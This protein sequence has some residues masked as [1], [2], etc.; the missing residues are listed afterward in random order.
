VKSSELLANIR[1]LAVLLHRRNEK[2]AETIL[3][4]IT[5]CLD[6][7]MQAGEN[8]QDGGM[9]RAQQT[10]FAI[11]EVRTLMTEGE[12]HTAATAARDAAREWAHS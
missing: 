12:F 5:G 2:Q 6:E 10:M 9:H 4:E 11:E 1:D 8:G 7:V 3:E